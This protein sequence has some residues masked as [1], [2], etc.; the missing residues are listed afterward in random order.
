MVSLI[1]IFNNFRLKQQGE[2]SSYE[3]KK[4][5]VHY[6]I[7]YWQERKATGVLLCCTGGNKNQQTFWKIVR[8]Y[9]R[10]SILC[11]SFDPYFIM[12]ILL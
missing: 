12:G 6:P 2:N 4:D 1:F 7:H 9:V 3:T 5:L 8:Q 10:K 11:F